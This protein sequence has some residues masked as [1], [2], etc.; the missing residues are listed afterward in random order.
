MHQQ[1]DVVNEGLLREVLASP[2]YRAR[3]AATRVLCYWRDRVPEPISLLQKLVGD[4]HPRV[5]LEAVRALSFFDSQEAID[6]ATE[7]LIYPVD[8]YLEYVYK[9]TMDTLEP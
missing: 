3:S 5:R 1:Q 7:V 8:P 6:A 2:D 9:E 4:E